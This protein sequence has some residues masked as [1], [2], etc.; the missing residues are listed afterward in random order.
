VFQRQEDRVV[1][2]GD[3]SF[4]AALGPVIAALLSGALFVELR[5]FLVCEKLASFVFLRALEGDL[6]LVRPD[7]L[8][9]GFSPGRFDGRPL[10]GVLRGR[11]GG[12]GRSS[13]TGNRGGRRCQNDGER[14]R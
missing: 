1:S 12:C 8:Q 5:D 9:V 14:T 6:E 4:A 13:L 3:V 2:A 11:C 10:A 7:S